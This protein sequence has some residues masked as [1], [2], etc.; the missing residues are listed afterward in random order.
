MEEG[1]RRLYLANRLSKLMTTNLF[2]DSGNLFNNLIES[3]E[4]QIGFYV[5]LIGNMKCR[6]FTAIESRLFFYIYYLNKNRVQLFE[7]SEFV[8]IKSRECIIKSS[9]NYGGCMT[10]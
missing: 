3:L 8:S 4:N 5:A 10:L 1:Q 7:V 6:R 9:L 2:N